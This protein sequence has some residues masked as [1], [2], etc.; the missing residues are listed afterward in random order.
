MK[1]MKALYFKSLNRP[2]YIMG[3]DRQ[4]FFLVLG[5]CAPIAYSA[6]FNFLMDLLAIGLF[7][8]GYIA[9]IFMTR[10]DPQF[11]PIYVRHIKYKNYYAPQPGVAAP[12]R[13]VKPSVPFY[14]GQKGLV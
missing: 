13:L 4:L 3:I 6:R 14:Q 5:L 1:G 9:A 7:M 10:S 8:V 12:I 11:M 2:F